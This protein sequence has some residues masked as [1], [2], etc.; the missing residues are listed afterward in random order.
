MERSRQSVDWNQYFSSIRTVCPWSWAAWGSDRILLE[1]WHG[2]VRDLEPYEAIV[3]ICRSKPRLAKKQAK[4]IEKKY[5]QYE[6]LVSAPSYGPNGTPVTV[7]IQ[8]DKQ[9]LD[10]L[11]NKVGYKQANP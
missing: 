6:F 11:R 3:Y 4:A 7:I 5:P 1:R 8:Q 9:K 10:Y 2:Q